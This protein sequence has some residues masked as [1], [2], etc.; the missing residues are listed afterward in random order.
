[1]VITMLSVAATMCHYLIDEINGTGNI[2]I[3]HHTEVAGANGEG[4]LEAL[5]LRDN[6]TDTTETVPASALFVLTGAD[7][8]T[9]WLPT[10][11]QRDEHGFVL[12]GSDLRH[13]DVPD[14]W[15][16]Q[17]PHCRSKPACPACSPP[18]TS[19]N[20]PS[21]ALPQRWAKVQSPPHS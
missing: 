14:G 8:H 3:R 15:P 7:P 11:V 12:T 6:T 18:A 5:I 19:V 9:G 2:D 13:G 4:H 10:A 20:T 21:D 16:L 17:R 1:V